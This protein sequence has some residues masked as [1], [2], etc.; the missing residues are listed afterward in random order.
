DLN[1][2]F[3]V[4]VGNQF[5]IYYTLPRRLVNPVSGGVSHMPMRLEG[6]AVRRRMCE[7]HSAPQLLPGHRRCLAHAITRPW[8]N[9]ACC[10]CQGMLPCA[11]PA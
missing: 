1:F 11:P 3:L 2:L 8:R 5:S 4:E 9:V 6:G 10:R 7:T